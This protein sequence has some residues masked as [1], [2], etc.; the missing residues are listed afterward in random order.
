MSAPASIH[1]RIPLGEGVA[2]PWLGLGT[3]RSTGP[4]LERAITFAASVGY[5]LFDTASLYGNEEEVGRAL[6]A[7]GLPR[8]E[9]FVTSK[10][11]NDRQGYDSTLRSFD[12]SLRRLGMEYL[13]LYLIHWP[14]PGKARDT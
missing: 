3:W 7:T 2:M 9:L 14:V 12:E 10:V 4:D 5:R 13:D 1:D 6:R 8:P 11:W